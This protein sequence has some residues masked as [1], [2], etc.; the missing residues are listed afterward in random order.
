MSKKYIHK[1]MQH[2]QDAVVYTEIGPSPKGDIILISTTER[3]DELACV[4][5][6]SYVAKNMIEYHEPRKG[7]LWLNI[8]SPTETYVH[9]SKPSE[10][11]HAGG[12][13]PIAQI[14][15]P[16]VEG[17]GLEKQ[18]CSKCHGIGWLEDK[19]GDGGRSVRCD[20]C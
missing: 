20:R 7:T 13:K 1:N 18:K 9:Y 16:W 10:A 14:K 5:A 11:K 19:I 12:M 6:P 4:L 2:R 3:G 8:Y 17:Q 15:V